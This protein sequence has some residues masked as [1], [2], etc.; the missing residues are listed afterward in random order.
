MNTRPSFSWRTTARLGL[1]AWFF[2]NLYEGLVGMPQ[3]LADA[4]PRRAP[5]LMGPGSPVRYYAPAAP[6]AVA[7]TAVSLV[8]SWKS[9]G[10]RR[11]ITLTTISMASAAALTAYL[12]RSVNLHLLTSEVALSEQTR[13]RMITTWHSTNA[14]RL[15]ALAIAGVSLSRATINSTDP[16]VSFHG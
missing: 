9:G 2:G 15:A 5:R 3:L 13:Q 10:D 11:L 1:T 4:Q 14:V 8:Q 16:A 7:G 12:I 6:L